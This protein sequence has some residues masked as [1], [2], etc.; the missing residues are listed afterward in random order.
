[1]LVCLSISCVIF[2]AA[3]Y[4]IVLFFN[5]D[6]FY[7]LASIVFYFLKLSILSIYIVSLF[8]NDTV[9]VFVVVV[10]I[11]EG[12]TYVLMI[13]CG[14]YCT[15]FIKQGKQSRDAIKGSVLSVHDCLYRC[16]I[17]YGIRF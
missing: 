6:C 1:M 15:L 16:C 8:M 3:T 11:F 14:I 4:S 9:L 5:A 10:C 13:V 2:L 17:I 12:E 7:L